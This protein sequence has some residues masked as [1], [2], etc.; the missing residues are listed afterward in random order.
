MA[1]GIRKAG[2][3][4]QV[5]PPFEGLRN[6]VTTE[7]PNPDSEVLAPVRSNCDATGTMV[8]VIRFQSSDNRKGTTG[9]MLSTILEPL[10]APMPRSQLLWKG[11]LMRLAIGLASRLASS[12]ALSAAGAGASWATGTPRAARARR[13]PRGGPYVLHVLDSCQ[14][15][16][17]HC[18]RV[19]YWLVWPV[20]PALSSVARP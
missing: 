1:V 4:P 10:F 7:S 3:T 20:V 9:W 18:K 12:A 17:T 5:M 11:T 14:D 6:A 2:P 8:R 16:Y 15:Q 13:R 19:K